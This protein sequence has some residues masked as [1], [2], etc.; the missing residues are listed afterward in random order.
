MTSVPI[1]ERTG[2][3]SQRSMGHREREVRLGMGKR[4]GIPRT[5]SAPATCVRFSLH[6]LGDPIL[7]TP[8]AWTYDFQMGKDIHYYYF[9][10]LPVSFVGAQAIKDH[11]NLQ[12]PVAQWP[13]QSIDLEH[14]LS[15]CEPGICW[16]CK[17]LDVYTL[18]QT[19]SAGSSS[20]ASKALW[21]SLESS[22]W[23]NNH[24]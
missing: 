15:K 8:W 2:E 7:L 10:I 12:S 13:L 20:Q 6:V 3:D 21:P 17:L 18:A 16:I 14:W 9:Q 5:P 24:C 22:L 4:P 19:C 1:E 11:L 23:V